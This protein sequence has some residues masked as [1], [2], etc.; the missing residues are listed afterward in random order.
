MF[1][2]NAHH[3]P[4]SLSAGSTSLPA[5]CAN[6]KAQETGNKICAL[7]E[8]LSVGETTPQASSLDTTADKL[9]QFVDRQNAR[10]SAQETEQIA[11][12]AMKLVETRFHGQFVSRRV[13]Q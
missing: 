3:Y 8:K 11:E 4:V 9:V 2:L 12:S 13:G 1:T 5:S 7:L 6:V 10:V